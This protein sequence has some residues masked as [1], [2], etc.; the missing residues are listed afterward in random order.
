MRALAIVLAALAITGA[1]AAQTRPHNLEWWLDPA[2]SVRTPADGDFA[3]NLG[4][5]AAYAPAYFGGDNKDAEFLPLPLIDVEWRGTLFASTQ[6]GVGIHLFRDQDVRAGFR[7]TADL[8]RDSGASAH[9][10]TL[11]DIDPAPEFGLYGEAF[12]GA[13][14]LQADIR[15][16]FTGHDGLLGSFGLAHGSRISESASL[17]FRGRLRVA[18]DEYTESFFAVSAAEARP[19]LPTYDASFGLL[20][21]D[22]GASFVWHFFK[23]AYVSLDATFGRLLGDAADSP[24]TEDEFY[25]NAGI[26]LG[27]R[28]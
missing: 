21:F 3:I 14:R 13:V 2:M 1:A 8:G 24:V 28:F 25:G 5:G 6:R 19:G 22:L 11:D 15:K 10:R 16:A 23:R 4:A 27:Y 7:V 18:D 9:L 12:I 26:V 20:N 17:F